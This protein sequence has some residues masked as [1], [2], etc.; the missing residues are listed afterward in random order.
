VARQL[1]DTR[2]IARQVRSY[3]QLLGI[4]VNVTRGQVTAGLRRHWGLNTILSPDGSDEKNRADHR[5]HAVDAAVI[6]MTNAKHLKNLARR[7]DFRREREP[8]PLP[9]PGFREEIKR[10]IEQ[11]VVSYAPT[12]RVRG[13]LHEETNYGK[14]PEPNEFVYRKPL[15]DLTF[16]EVGKIRDNFIRGLVE[17]RLDERC[18]GWRDKAG[19]ERIPAS[20]F[21]EKDPLCLPNR[22]GDPIPVRKVRIITTISNPI[23]LPTE[24]PYR[25]VKPGENHHLEIF[26]YTDKKGRPVYEAIVVSLFEAAQRLRRREPVVSR[27]H[28]ERPDAQFVMSLCKNDMVRYRENGGPWRYYRIQKFSGS[29]GRFDIFLRFHTAST[30]EN[31]ETLVRLT[32]LKPTQQ[33]EK[34]NVSVLGKVTPAH[35]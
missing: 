16:N 24:R 32:T 6:A 21:P 23:G 4:P 31:K 35:D 34:V 30:I 28:P 18:P 11:I 20:V 13:P 22:H 25:F 26:K 9:W 17:K 12:R 7:E 15:A 29:D 27:V 2:Y 1:N 19:T 3:L 14:T 5:H 10:V 33:I 8:F